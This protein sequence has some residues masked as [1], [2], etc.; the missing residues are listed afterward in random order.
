MHYQNQSSFTFVHHTNI[1]KTMFQYDLF[2]ISFS[3]GLMMLLIRLKRQKYTVNI[4]HLC[5]NDC[6]HLS[7]HSALKKRYCGFLLLLE[8][9][10]KYWMWL[11]SLW[12]SKIW[13]NLGF[14][15]KEKLDKKNLVFS[16]IVLCFFS[17]FLCAMDNI[18]NILLMIC[19]INI[20]N[21]IAKKNEMGKKNVRTSTTFG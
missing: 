16:F 6:K 5:I 7:T 11:W 2:P 14:W 18:C 3:N 20:E 12:D 9:I 1:T 13:N 17:A 21:T 10:S 4:F 8:M 19:H 15:L